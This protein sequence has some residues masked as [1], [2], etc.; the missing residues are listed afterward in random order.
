[1]S[2][3][4]HS[5]PRSVSDFCQL[6]VDIGVK[7][8]VTITTHINC[9]LLAAQEEP[10]QNVYFLAQSIG[11][12]SVTTLEKGPLAEEEKKKRQGR[13]L[14]RRTKKYTELK[15]NQTT[16]KREEVYGR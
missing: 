7:H 5:G 8:Q 2:L 4:E 3:H 15:G 1:M 13:G 11:E 6:L 9:P 12:L 16:V 14:G 10:Y